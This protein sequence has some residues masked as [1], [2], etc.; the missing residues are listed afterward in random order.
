MEVLLSNST[1]I[2]CSSAKIEMNGMNGMRENDG[3]WREP[4]RNDLGAKTM[5]LKGK[6]MKV[7]VKMYGM[8]SKKFSSFSK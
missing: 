5:S 3:G 7:Y 2:K 4:D 6:C 8:G 1:L